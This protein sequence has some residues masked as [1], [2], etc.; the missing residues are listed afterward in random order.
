MEEVERIWAFC[1]ELVVS[2]HLRVLASRDAIHSHAHCMAKYG[3]GVAEISEIE[4][5][6]LNLILATFWSDLRVS[7]IKACEKKM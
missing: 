5:F 2:V 3:A 6:S 7:Y 4:A 1:G